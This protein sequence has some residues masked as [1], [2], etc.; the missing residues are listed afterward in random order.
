[1]EQRYTLTDCLSFVMMRRLKIEAAVAADE[2]FRQ[3]GFAT[4]P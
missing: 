3:E 1:V 2:H 4:L